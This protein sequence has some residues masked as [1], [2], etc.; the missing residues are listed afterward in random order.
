LYAATFGEGVVFSADGGDHWQTLGDAPSRYLH[1]L[2][3]GRYNGKSVVYASSY[4]VGVFEWFL[5]STD[6][7]EYAEINEIQRTPGRDH[8]M[9]NYPNPFNSRTT[10]QYEV[11]HSSRVVLRIFNIAG[12][13]VRYLFDEYQ[14]KGE[15]SIAWD[16]R[17]DYG[18]EVASGLYFCHLKYGNVST[19]KKLLFIK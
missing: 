1:L 11:L 4:G 2:D 6:V 15:Y 7:R 13:T 18:R 19:A 3:I 17:D 16:G 10:I 9:Q 14:S 12:Q 8:L 5:Q